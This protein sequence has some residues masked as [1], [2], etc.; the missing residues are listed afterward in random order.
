MVIG[1][2]SAPL[3]DIVSYNVYERLL[4]LDLTRWSQRR[5]AIRLARK[6]AAT[7]A[8]AK[9]GAD[10]IPNTKPSHALKDYS[11]DYENPAYG[12]LHVSLK[13]NQLHFRFHSFNSP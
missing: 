2:H 9:A 11:G 8:R 3:Y 7:E 13:D 4:G 5:L 10:R 6:K 1:D 12:I